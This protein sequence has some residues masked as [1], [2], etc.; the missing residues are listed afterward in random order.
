MAVIDFLSR[1]AF[2]PA[3]TYISKGV[4]WRLLQSESGLFVG[5][6]RNLESKE[7][8]FFCLDQRSGK[9][10]WERR[11][12][13]EAWW[14][15]VEAVHGDRVF[16]HGFLKPDMPQHMGITAVDLI[17]GKIAWNKSDFSFI[18]AIDGSVFAAKDSALL[19]EL[20]CRT[21]ET[22]H[23][24]GDNNEVLRAARTRL[25]TR[26]TDEPE[27]PV[28]FGTSSP[29]D[30]RTATF[31]S[32]HSRVQNVVGSIEGLEKNEHFFY[33]Y[34]ETDGGSNAEGRLRNMLKVINLKN[35]EIVLTETLNKS[36]PAAVPDSF[37]IHQDMLYFIKDRSEL[38][39][40]NIRELTS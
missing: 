2:A 17:T 26:E 20:D 14:I 3:W 40:V 9:V 6:D 24:W 37:F 34:H 39:A 19:F 8:T 28:L 13:N 10:L 21:G 36:V 32:R 35:G 30:E 25:R 23:A 7:T 18:L 5:E 31:V 29:M 16:L 27:F 22:L 38:T 4:L 12:F 1:K 15:G 11:A 33:S